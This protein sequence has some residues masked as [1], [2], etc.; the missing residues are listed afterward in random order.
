M[1]PVLRLATAGAVALA[2]ASLPST[3]LA[4]QLT[5]RYQAPLPLLVYVIGA[6]LAVGMSFVFVMIRNAPPP[7]AEQQHA[8]TVPVW[9]R[10]VLAAL[11][12]IAWLW[13]VAQTL[14]GG[15]GSA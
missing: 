11:G 15:S 14:I 12:L 13:I 4:H 6:A 1:R 2:G 9:L 10:N 7:R 8:V 3:V 5:E